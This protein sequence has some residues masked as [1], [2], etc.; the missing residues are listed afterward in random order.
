MN[1]QSL[2]H[3]V[4][5]VPLALL[6]AYIGSPRFLGTMGSARVRRILDAGLEKNRYTVLHDLLLP[7]G[8]GTV[9]IQHIVV[10]RFG[11]WVIDSIHR[12]GLISGTEVQSRWQ[13][14]SLGRTLRFDNPIH[15]NFLKIQSLERL[16]QLPHSR[17]YPMIVFSGQR[18]FKSAV[19]ASVLDAKKLISRIHAQRREV[20][21][22]EEADKVVL[23]L[24]DSN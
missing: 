16:L 15:T 6:A 23:R 8:G 7:A 21:A 14:K 20:L 4:W 1:I 10:S 13:Q 9:S 5:I 11:I 12:T 17:F 19:P 18:G 22:P 2:V 3:L 24:R